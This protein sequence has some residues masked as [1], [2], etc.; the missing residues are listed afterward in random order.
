[1]T[2]RMKSTVAWYTCESVSRKDRASNLKRRSSSTSRLVSSI[3]R[4]CW[5]G[6]LQAQQKRQPCEESVER[7]ECVAELPALFVIPVEEELIMVQYPAD[8]TRTNETEPHRI[9]VC[10]FMSVAYNTA[11]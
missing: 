9:I 10:F 8:N 5:I 6:C 3:W 1:M 2:L 11:A 4:D 7:A